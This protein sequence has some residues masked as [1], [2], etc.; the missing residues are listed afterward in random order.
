MTVLA[1][2]FDLDAAIAGVGQR[3]GLPARRVAGA[4]ASC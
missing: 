3:L 2:Q 4:A 1:K